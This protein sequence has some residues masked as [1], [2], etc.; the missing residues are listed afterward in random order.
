MPIYGALPI[1]WLMTLEV[2][3]IRTTPGLVAF[4][5]SWVLINGL[6]PAPSPQ[7]TIVMVAVAQ[8]AV[9]YWVLRPLR[10]PSAPPATAT[11]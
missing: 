4:G 1:L 5:A 2:D 11:G 9:L 7:V 3:R 6:P 8:V 10:W